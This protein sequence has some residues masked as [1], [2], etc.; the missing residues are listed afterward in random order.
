MVQFKDRHSL[1]WLDTASN[2]SI[3]RWTKPQTVQ[4]K[5]GHSPKLPNLKM[6]TASNGSAFNRSPIVWP[7]TLH[8]F[9]LKLTLATISYPVEQ[10]LAQLFLNF[11]NVQHVAMRGCRQR[12][13]K[14]VWVSSHLADQFL[15]REHTLATQWTVVLNAQSSQGQL[16][17]RSSKEIIQQVFHNNPFFSLD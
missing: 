4:F 11:H 13:S 16:A 12:E 8:H 1:K 3:L 17:E 6:N 9:S 2:G 14:T 7:S 15:M 10:F 5:D